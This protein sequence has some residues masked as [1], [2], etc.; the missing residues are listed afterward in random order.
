[1]V[2][3]LAAFQAAAAAE[4]QTEGG[5]FDA[6]RRVEVGHL[7]VAEEQRHALEVAT[8][9]LGFGHVDAP[10]GC[11]GEVCG[12]LGQVEP[13]PVGNAGAAS[14]DLCV[15]KGGDQGAVPT[16]R[17]GCQVKGF[18]EGC[19]LKTVNGGMDQ[20]GLVPLRQV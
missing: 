17:G 18:A 7:D 19:F 14:E 10:E 6:A 11:A 12:A 20:G 5:C 16:E 15:D 4:G 9:E 8:G 2:E 13:G 3:E 1:M